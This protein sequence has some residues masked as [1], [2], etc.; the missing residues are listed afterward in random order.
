LSLHL[1]LHADPEALALGH[2]LFLDSR[3]QSRPD[4]VKGSAL[5]FL[6]DRAYLAG[7]EKAEGSH[8]TALGA[9]SS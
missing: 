6:A 3:A 7:H 9:C 2:V 8:A 1:P 5:G 4:R